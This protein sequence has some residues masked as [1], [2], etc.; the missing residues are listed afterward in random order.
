[1]KI[2]RLIFKELVAQFDEPK[3]SVL[4]GPRQVGKT[5]LLREL[6]AEAQKKRLTTRYFDLEIPDDLLALGATDKEQFD[7]LM[8]S[9]D[10]IFVDELYRLK[11]ISHVFKAIF[12]SRKK[13]PK[14]FASGSSALELHTHL[15]ESM[16][17][18]VIFNR[19]FPLSLSELRQQP[20]YRDE[21]ALLTGGMPGLVNLVKADDIPKELQ[22][23]VATYINRDIKGLV[24]EENVRAFNHLIYLLAEQQGSVVV[25]A[26]LA[27]EIGMSKPT[28][29]KYL[30]LLSQTYVCHTVPSYARNLGNELKKSRKQFLFDIGIRNSLIKDFRPL[31][32]RNDAG[33]LKEG[34]VALNLVR[35]LKANMEL[36]FWRTKQGHEVD[37]IVVKNRVPYPIEVKSDIKRAEIPD[38]LK[39]F[40]DAYADAS[41]A[42]V[43]NDCLTDEVS[44]Q[45][46]RVRFL[47]WTHAEDIDFVHQAM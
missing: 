15:K 22:N 24:R 46:R 23:I 42:V 38:G 25:A 16:A 20:R 37:F 47:P 13:K 12:D 41:E 32:E 44:Y 21:D 3:I 10:V 19:I 29:E 39:R 11:N 1:M 8:S 36:R 30:E 14:I 4:I 31:S 40:L 17:G 26:N 34:F 43:F 27:N 5:F 9:G 33:F 45:G 7:V 18:R 2:K 35:Q 28:V 6:E